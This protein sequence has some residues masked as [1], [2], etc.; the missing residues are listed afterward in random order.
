MPPPAEQSVID[1]YQRRVPTSGPQLKMLEAVERQRLILRHP[2]SLGDRR[3]KTKQQLPCVASLLR[4]RKSSA[5]ARALDPELQEYQS[6]AQ[7][8][9]HAAHAEPFSGD[10]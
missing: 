1:E 7:L 5:R 10:P 9:G 3:P 4:Y 8:L 2:Q 6:R